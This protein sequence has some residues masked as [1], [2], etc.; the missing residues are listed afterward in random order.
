MS[1][2]S[3][4]PYSMHIHRPT[5]EDRSSVVCMYYYS[6]R[7]WS[8]IFSKKDKKFDDGDHDNDDD[9]DQCDEDGEK[10]DHEF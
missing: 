2:Q 5:K 7:C 1:S 3:K 9:E 4:G 10:E 8:R 6:F